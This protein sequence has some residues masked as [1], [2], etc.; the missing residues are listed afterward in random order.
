[1]SLVAQSSGG[2]DYEPRFGTRIKGSGLF[3]EM[4][5]QRFRVASLSNWVRL[6]EDGKLS[7]AGDKP[8]TPEQMELARLRAELAR[9]T[10]ERDIAKKAAAYFAQDLLQGTPGFKK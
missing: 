9:M 1:M 4:I 8:V 10:M 7:G 2:K 5:A 6:S 3:A